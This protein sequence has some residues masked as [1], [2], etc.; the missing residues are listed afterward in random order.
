MDF[1]KGCSKFE[2]LRRPADRSIRLNGY[3]LV[4]WLWRVNLEVRPGLAALRV[5]G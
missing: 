1:W 2:R 3:D 5:A 4:T